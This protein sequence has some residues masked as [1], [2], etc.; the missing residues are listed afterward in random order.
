MREGIFR[1]YCF[2]PKLWDQVPNIQRRRWKR[3]CPFLG[4]P[5]A[6]CHRLGGRKPQKHILSRFWRPDI[7]GPR[8]PPHAAP[9]GSGGESA[10]LCLLQ[11]WGIFAVW[12]PSFD[13]CFSATTSP[14]ILC[15]SAPSP[16][17][18]RHQ[19]L[20]V[21]LTLNQGKFHLKILNYRPLQR[22]RSEVLS[23]H[24]LGGV[25]GGAHCSTHY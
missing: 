20:D 8:W 6:K 23:G 9:G 15:L 3:T 11:P 17:L 14:S 2:C 13:L 5:P 24:E 10:F 16:L 21:G 12:Q 7:P 1:K 19:S 25:G 4:L 18:V 22:S